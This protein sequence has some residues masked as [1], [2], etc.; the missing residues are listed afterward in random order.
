[1]RPILGIV[2]IIY[3]LTASL[4]AINTPPWQTP[5]EPAHYNYVAYLATQGQLPVLQPGDWDQAYLSQLT[6]RKFPPELSVATLRYESHQP[7]LYYALAAPM[8]LATQN[9][10]EREQDVV[11]RFLSVILGG[12]LLFAAYRILEM[13]FPERPFIP[14]T[15]TAFIA[16]LPQHIAMTAA[17]NNDTLAELVLAAV[18]FVSLVAIRGGLGPR[19]SLILGVLLGLAFLSKTTIYVPALLAVG[20]AFWWGG[21]DWRRLATILGLALLISGW[22]FIR[23]MLTY[24]G[25]DIFG[26]ARHDSI[27]LGQPTTPQWLSQFGVGGIASAFLT[28]TFLSFWGQFGWMGVVMDE[29][30]YLAL[31]FLSLF[32][33]LGFLLALRRRGEWSTLQKRSTLL[34]GVWLAIVFAALVWY[35]LR[36]VQHQ[37]R[38]LFPALIPLS[39]FL[40]LSLGYWASLLA[41]LFPKSATV[42]SSLNLSESIIFAAFY[43]GFI[44]LDLI[45]LYWFIIPQLTL[46]SA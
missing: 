38:Y 39:L 33:V 24:G 41:R 21:R 19:R 9:L 25:L 17:V 42:Q 44:A 1:M 28:T 37:G 6:S 13:I 46:P 29:R 36:F 2:T 16:V 32:I 10:S 3:L 40:A 20:A 26:W 22:W 34:F 45:A 8:Y 31:F 23:N 4:Y 30:I 15:A 35:N 14:L 7:P 12:M 11:L 27:V 43:L 18:V 5:D